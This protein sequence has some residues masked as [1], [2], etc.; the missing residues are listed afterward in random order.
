MGVYLL[1][2]ALLVL[3]DMACCVFH[4][5]EIVLSSKLRYFSSWIGAASHCCVCWRLM[6]QPCWLTFTCKNRTL[7]FYTVH[8]HLRNSML[9]VSMLKMNCFLLSWQL[10]RIFEPEMRFRFRMFFE[11]DR[12]RDVL[13][14]DLVEDVVRRH[15]QRLL[16]LQQLLDQQRVQVVRVH[17]VILASGKER[18]MRWIKDVFSHTLLLLNVSPQGKAF[19]LRL[20]IGQDATLTW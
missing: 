13:G 8:W 17:D 20:K 15:R 14:Q 12:L 6:E 16:P 19:F 9:K 11:Q 1:Q 18:P 7:W 3:D 10:T 2:M 4:Y 5:L